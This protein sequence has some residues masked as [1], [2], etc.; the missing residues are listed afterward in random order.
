MIVE[1][2]RDIA[3]IKSNALSCALFLYIN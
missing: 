1:R 2:T 3:S